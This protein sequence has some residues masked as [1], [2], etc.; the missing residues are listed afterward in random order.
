[1][2]SGNLSGTL[3]QRSCNPAR[4]PAKS[5]GIDS[6]K[7][8]S[9]RSPAKMSGIET[10]ACRQIRITAINSKLGTSRQ[11]GVGR[12]RVRKMHRAEAMHGKVPE[13]AQ[14]IVFLMN[15]HASRKRTKPRIP[16]SLFGH[17]VMASRDRLLGSQREQHLAAGWFQWLWM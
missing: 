6:S 2:W 12:P 7:S 14:Q 9:L 8:T 11:Q 16:R 15:A 13:C 1:M 5:A 17:H 10:V 3:L 4:Q